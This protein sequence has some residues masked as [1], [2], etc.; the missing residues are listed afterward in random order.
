[1]DYL[2]YRLSAPEA[3]TRAVRIEMPRGI[4]AFDC[5]KRHITAG[6]VNNADKDKGNSSSGTGL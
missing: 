5:K 3:H 4:G 2:N 6:R 1:M